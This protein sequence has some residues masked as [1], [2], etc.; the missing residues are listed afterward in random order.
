MKRFLIRAALIAVLS[1]APAIAA[2]ADPPPTTDADLVGATTTTATV[3]I[4]VKTGED[5]SAAAGTIHEAIIG[6][7]TAVVLSL[8][9]LLSSKLATLIGFNI[10]LKDV[11][12]DIDMEKYTRIVIDKA[13]VFGVNQIG[14]DVSNVDLKVGAL[15][16]A[17]H[18]I[19]S[20]FPEVWSWI[21]RDRD[22]VIDY[23]QGHLPGVVVPAAT[24]VPPP[25]SKVPVI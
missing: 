3:P 16:W 6:T 24:H 17:A 9:T 4:V 2:F 8:L 25:G 19:N 12:R 7:A 1:I 23:I 15:R 18:F 10:Q 22:G 21:D 5:F 13:W 14:G 11:A 20:Q